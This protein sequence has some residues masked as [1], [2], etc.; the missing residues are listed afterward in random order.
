MWVN[1]SNQL[2]SEVVDDNDSVLIGIGT[3]VRVRPTVYWR[4]KAHLA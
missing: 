4:S 2:P 1:N 3:R